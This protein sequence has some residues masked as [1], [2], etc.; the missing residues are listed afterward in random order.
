MRETV[1]VRLF[2]VKEDGSMVDEYENVVYYT[3]DSASNLTLYDAN[4]KVVMMYS[5]TDWAS[6]HPIDKEN[7]SAL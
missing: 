7:P 2:D 4:D 1:T 3:V 6:I 5:W